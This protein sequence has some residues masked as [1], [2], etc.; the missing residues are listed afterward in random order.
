[1]RLRG[2]MAIRP[3][4]DTLWAKP[5]ATDARGIA[6]TG[7]LDTHPR[8]QA[9]C[10]MRLLETARAKPTTQTGESPI[11]VMRGHLVAASIADLAPDRQES[12]PA[13]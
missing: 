6:T 11:Q 4:A 12:P 2:R 5:H 7:S 1:M 8:L 9:A 13:Q 10:P 3:G